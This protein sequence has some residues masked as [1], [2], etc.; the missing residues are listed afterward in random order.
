M[1]EKELDVCGE[2]AASKK[3]TPARMSDL[4]SGPERHVLG[5][6]VLRTLLA[7]PG[8]DVHKTP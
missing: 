7:L 4:S 6:H 5:R 1:R 2:N 8:L 3:W